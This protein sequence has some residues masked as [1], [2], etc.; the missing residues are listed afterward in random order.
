MDG[1]TIGKI[2][3]IVSGVFMAWKMRDRYRLVQPV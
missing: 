2:A 3:Q 1:I